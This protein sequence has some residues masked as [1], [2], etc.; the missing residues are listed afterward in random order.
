MIRPRRGIIGRV[1]ELGGRVIIGLGVAIAAVAAIGY[2]FVY[3]NIATPVGRGLGAFEV[4]APGEVV[5]TWLDD[6]RPA[7]LLQVEDEALVVDARTP[8]VLGEPQFLV[9]WCEEAGAFLDVVRGETY[10]PGGEVMGAS[11]GTGLNLYVTEPADDGRTVGVRD[12]LRPAGTAAADTEALDCPAGSSWVMHAPQPR[13]IF[14]PSVAADG[15]PPGWI[16]LEGTLQVVD[17]EARLCDS[18]DGACGSGADVTGIDPAKVE[19]GAGLFLGRVLDHV[20]ENLVLV[21]TIPD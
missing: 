20:V 17:G 9:A 11:A 14:D 5:A 8:H 6:G 7:Y 12:E 2:V 4:P 21:P 10:A 16:W 13:E 3:S 15:E 1:R 19:G 18:L